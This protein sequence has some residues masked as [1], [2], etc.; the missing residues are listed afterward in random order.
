MDFGIVKTAVQTVAEV[1]GMVKKGT[2][3]YSTNSLAEVSK[4]TRVEPLTILSKDLLNLEYMPDVQ[5]TLLNIFSAY[6]LQAVNIMTNVRDVEVI[7]LLDRLNPDRDSTGFMLSEGM[8]Q[9]GEKNV[10]LLS[11]ESY[12]HS[13]PMSSVGTIGLEND[14]NN[15]NDVTNLAVGKMLKVT[16]GFKQGTEIG[17]GIGSNSATG[18]DENQG[19]SESVTLDIAVRLAA[20]VVPDATIL[21]LL[22][23]K[24]ED[25]SLLERYH[26]WRSGRIS[27]IKDLI[28]AQDLIDE[29]KRAS[30]GDNTDTVQEII[31]RV[32]NA[33][34]YGLLTQNPSLVSASNL[35]VIS[36]QTA[37][38]VEMKLGGKLSNPR[39]R[40]KAFDN[41]Y[42][43]IIAV[44]DREYERVTFYTR[45]TA[46][47][48]DVSIKE[49][50]A[51]NKGSKGPDIGD[52]LRAMNI[53]SPLS[54]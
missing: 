38:D 8:T 3:Y 35:F 1:V 51:A 22:S 14:K 53:G 10:S 25:N 39:I 20:S 5:S 43:M 24:T 30:I 16:I 6:Y 23:F 11:L 34:S 33:K 48:T 7:R 46:A 26:A 27:F 47:S 49:I 29:W 4:L 15:L 37:R 50:K 42:A 21:H 28:F 45:G 31:R 44:V 41:T 2:N 17:A 18:K 54:F 52:M 12:K 9:R 19:K 36:E 32:N 13:L 40:Q